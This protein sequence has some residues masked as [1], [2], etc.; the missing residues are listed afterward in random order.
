MKHKPLPKNIVVISVRGG[1][2]QA[3]YRNGGAPVIL[4]DYDDIEQGGEAKNYFVCPLSRLTGETAKHVKR[5]Y[6]S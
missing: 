1:V 2:V 5:L 6:R 3:V 4:V